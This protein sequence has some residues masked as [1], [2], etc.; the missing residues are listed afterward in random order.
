LSSFLS[1]IIGSIAKH[2]GYLL[3]DVDVHVHVVL[4][5]VNVNVMMMQVIVWVILASFILSFNQ[6]SITL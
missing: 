5:R 2:G 6:P 3:N 4:L 1:D